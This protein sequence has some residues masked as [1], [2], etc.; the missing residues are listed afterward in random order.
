MI[1]K[2]QT[3][4]EMLKKIYAGIQ[5]SK[6]G[7]L[8]IFLGASAG[9]GKTYAMIKE[10]VK[11]K[12]ENVDVVIGYIETHDRPETQKILPDNIEYLPLKA[13]K[14]NN[15]SLAEFDIDAALARNPRAII[16]DELAHSNAPGSRN[17]KRYQ[18]IYELINAGI[19]VYTALNIQHIESLNDIVMQITNIKV[20]ETVPDQ[21][22]RDADEIVIIDLPPE[23]LI[24]RLKNGDIYPKEQIQAALD[25]FFR[26]GNLTALREIALRKTAQKIDQQVLEYRNAKDIMQV[27]P[28]SDKLLLVLEPGYSSEK[29]VRYAKNTFDKGFNSWY[30][31][32][33]D[34]GTFDKRSHRERQNIAELL[35]LAKELGATPVEIVGT[36]QAL[37]ISQCVIENNINTL[38]LAQYR[39]PLYYRLFGKSLAERVSEII[40]EININLINQEENLEY[41][42]Y[43]EHTVKSNLKLNYRK[44]LLRAIYFL[45]VFGLL[46]VLLQP[47][48]YVTNNQNVL[49]IYLF[50]ILYI[51]RGRGYASSL[52][53]A[54]LGTLS[55]DFFFVP[56]KFSFAVTDSTYIV[57][58]FIMTGF[59]IFFN[60]K[61]GNFRYQLSRLSKQIRHNEL[62][63]QFSQKLAESMIE[64]QVLEAVDTYFAQMFKFEYVLLIPN[65][66]ESLSIKLG[67]ASSNFDDKIAKWVFLNNR[68]AGANTNT[69]AKN[70]LAYYPLSTSL[71]ARGVLAITPTD[72][73]D[74]FM[75]HNQTNLQSCIKLLATTIERIHFT[76]VAIETAVSLSKHEVN[77]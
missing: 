41:I 18:D 42:G 33:L 21:V 77:K 38:M 40:P 10:A 63:L 9:V 34:D 66:Q 16:V 23:E 28:N 55:F 36:D 26:K 43:P 45:A 64:S 57:T 1:K 19:D 3:P 24:E 35:D 6:R 37:A 22:I 61:M 30:I 53:A 5:K 17:A 76:Q 27:W 51:N 47:L 29:M 12:D 39:M 31:G 71:R 44:T 69:F 11:L 20:N 52:L 4:E 25:N 48:S 14:Y 72:K 32:Y 75:P 15:A 56:P 67:Y 46:G 2:R 13:L 54:F 68:H 7:R 50:T 58:F 62:F 74:F 60:F 49:L 65:I 59:T 70:E 8:K 73:L